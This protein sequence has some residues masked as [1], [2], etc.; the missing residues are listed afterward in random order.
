MKIRECSKDNQRKITGYL[1]VKNLH[2]FKMLKS[3]FYVF[4]IVLM[5]ASFWGSLYLVWNTLGDISIWIWNA[6]PKHIYFTA[7]TSAGTAALRN[8]GTLERWH[9]L[10]GVVFYWVS[11]E[12]YILPPILSTLLPDALRYQQVASCSWRS[13][14]HVMSSSAWWAYH[15]HLISKNIPYLSFFFLVIGSQKCENN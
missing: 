14:L 4:M 6:P 8:C 5:S 15:F 2:A 9:L 1:A 10:D 11:F 7:W 12:V 3:M 13:Y